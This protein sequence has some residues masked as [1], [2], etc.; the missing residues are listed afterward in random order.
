M[1]SAQSMQGE[2]ARRVTG[3]T[4]G[5][6]GSRLSSTLSPTI[7]GAVT[8]RISSVCRIISSSP[9]QRL[10]PLKLHLFSVGIFNG[11][12]DTKQLDGVEGTR[13]QVELKAYELS[14]CAAKTK[15]L[16]ERGRHIDT[17]L[18]LT[19]VTPDPANKN[20]WSL[21]SIIL[22]M[23]TTG[24][25]GRRCLVPDKRLHFVQHATQRNAPS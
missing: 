4:W 11:W 2:M 14:A 10:P 8:S 20:H 1:V 17:V 23:T 5:P 9:A 24:N 15:I 16:S 3:R 7:A 13:A 25:L 6:S 18:S 22:L 19:I 21:L 12:R